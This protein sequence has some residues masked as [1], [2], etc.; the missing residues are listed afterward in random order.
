MKNLRTGNALV[1]LIGISA[2]IR[3]FLAFNLELGNDEVYYLT[4]ALYPDL[5]HF[6]HPPMVGFII[7]LFSFNLLF[8]S[9]LFLRLG[10][11]VFGSLSIYLI[12]L[13]GREIKDATTGFYAALLYSTSVYGFIITGLF[14][15]PDT[16]QMMFWLLSVFFVLKVFSQDQSNRQKRI[17]FILTGIFTGLAMLSKYTSVFIW[18]GIISYILIFERKWLKS[19]WLY[20]S[21]F[22]TFIIFT[23]VIYWN[24]SNHFISLSYQGERVNLFSQVLRPDYFL[25]ELLG[26]FLY[27]NPVNVVLIVISLFMLLLHKFKM[28]DK[29]MK[30]ILLISLPLILIFIFI[31]FFRRT[32]PHWTAPGYTTLI[33]V[34]AVYLR[35]KNIRKILIPRQIKV[36]GGLLVTIILVGYLQVKVGLIRFTTP[37][38]T[39][40]TELGEYDVSLEITGW[41]QIGNAFANRLQKDNANNQYHNNSVLISHRWFPAA[42]LDYYAGSPNGLNT[43]AIGS[44]Y[45]IH[46]YYWI[47]RYRGGFYYGLDGYFITTSYDYHDPFRIYSDFFEWI[48]ATDTIKIV[49]GK[50]HVMNAFIYRLEDMKRLPVIK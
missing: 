16:P 36:A 19:R 28:P 40:P 20:L 9:E 30:L 26:E 12:Y 23:P 39:N 11:V 6:D 35:E 14:I 10:S 3:T 5:S 27:N 45:D 21:M 15:L 32:L 46:K 2:L 49:R 1:I 29:R 37:E 31:S 13:I 7:Q 33:L 22:L 24:A 44:L 38:D 18:T 4:Y 47:N 43:L 41:K 8:D 25:M 48:E 50:K 42:N 17:N 34:S